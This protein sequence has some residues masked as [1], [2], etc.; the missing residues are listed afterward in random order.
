MAMIFQE[1][2]KY[3]YHFLK[4]RKKFLGLIALNIV[5]LFWT[6]VLPEI[7]IVDYGHLLYLIQYVSILGVFLS[8]KN[9]TVFFLSPT[10]ITLSY[11]CLSFWGG[12]YVVSRGIMLDL[13]YYHAFNAFKSIKFITFFLLFSNFLVLVSIPFKKFINN[14][15]VQIFKNPVSINVY[16]HANLKIAFL[17]IL[18]ILFS[19][20]SVNLSFLGGSEDSDF[21]YVFKLAISIFLVIILSS[22][23]NKI[24]YIFYLILL[25]IFTIGHYDSKREILFVLILIGLFEIVHNHIN[26]KINIKQ[27]IISLISIALIV[28]IVLISSI[29]RGYGNFELESPVEAPKYGK[30]YIKSENIQKALVANFELSSVYGNS[31]NAINYVHS[32]Q[33]DYLYGKTFIKILFIPIP[34]SVF[35][36]KPR[37]MVDIYTSKFAPSFRARGG[38]YPVIIY[39]ESYWNFGILCFLFIYALFYILNLYYLKMYNAIKTRKFN[40]SIIFIIYMYITLIQFIRGSGIELWFIYGILAIP[41]VVILKNLVFKKLKF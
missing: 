38:S 14:G 35:P 10:F 1:N 5:L 33:V 15:S 29:S 13:K 11:L 34:R 6:I 27:L 7:I 4:I 16:K 31:S 23:K 24:K 41:L 19:L 26:F 39:A 20:I 3:S 21:S 22:Y 36:D 28:Y 32:N 12:H 2:N 8:I 40:F 30:Q 37:S 17:L 25:S 9:N 18:I